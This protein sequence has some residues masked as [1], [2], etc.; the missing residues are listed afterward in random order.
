MHSKLKPNVHLQSNW[1]EPELDIFYRAYRNMYLKISNC[2]QLG[3]TIDSSKY[4]RIRFLKLCEYHKI[5][6]FSTIG[7]LW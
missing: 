1:V 3:S 4:A 6:L 5:L 7:S 2:E